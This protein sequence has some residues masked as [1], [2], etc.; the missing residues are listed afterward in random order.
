MIPAINGCGRLCS[1]LHGSGQ[2]ISIPDLIV[3]HRTFASWAQALSPR[4]EGHVWGKNRVV[5]RVG[6]IPF[7]RSISER[8]SSSQ[9]ESSD[10]DEGHAL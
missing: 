3:A 4:A 2:T 5:A 9:L 8:S 7:G 1:S 6:G 10:K